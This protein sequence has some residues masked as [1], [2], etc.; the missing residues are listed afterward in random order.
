MKEFMSSESSDEEVDESGNTVK[1]VI[2]I[3]PLT[4][5]GA[6]VNRLIQRL[7]SR[8][9]SNMSKQSLQQTRPRVIG[10]DSSRPKPVSF[11]D[12]FWGFT[13]P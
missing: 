8:A 6:K 10:P 3:K 12:D 2:V 7:D 5:R 4:W 13:A 9:K 11:S 1:S